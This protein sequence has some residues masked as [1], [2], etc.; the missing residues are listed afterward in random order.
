[1]I[2]KSTYFKIAELVAPEILLTEKEDD[3]WE[4]FGEKRIRHLD[5]LRENFSDKIAVNGNGRKY[6]GL[7]TMDCKEGAP[8]SKHKFYEAFDLHA[9]NDKDNV[10]LKKLLGM[11]LINPE[12]YGISRIEDPDVTFKGNWLHV[13]IINNWNGFHIFKP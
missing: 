2:Y 8:K 3:L 13:E 5:L 4:K 12:K 1:M 9:V 6:S 11:I 10:K 7:R